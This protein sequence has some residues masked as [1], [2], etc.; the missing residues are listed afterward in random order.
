MKL[1]EKTGDS[2]SSY[3]LLK[4]LT[5]RSMGLLFFYNLLKCRTMFIKKIMIKATSRG[6][7]TTCKI[8]SPWPRFLKGYLDPSQ[9]VESRPLIEMQLHGRHCGRTQIWAA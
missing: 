9:S 7:I 6:R 2:P 3:L 5:E 1:K 8:K 4:P